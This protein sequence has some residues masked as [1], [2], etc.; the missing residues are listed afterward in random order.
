MW[1]SLVPHFLGD[2]SNCTHAKDKECLLWLPGIENYELADMLED[3]VDEQA[4]ILAR[5]SNKYTT[6]S[7]ESFNAMYGKWAP[8]KI[9]WNRID[10]R[11][12]ASVIRQNDQIL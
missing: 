5:I 6:Q 9:N 12:T 4:V 1:L 3:F 2:H 10:G 8:K 11:I 7:V